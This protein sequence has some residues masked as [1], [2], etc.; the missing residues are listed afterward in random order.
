MKNLFH[1]LKG[2]NRLNTLAVFLLTIA[3]CVTLVILRIQYT[4]KVTFIFLVWNIFLA[5]IPYAIST[6]L[7]LYH[8]KIRYRWLLTIPFLC[9]LCFFPNA[10]Y[11]L[12]DLFHSVSRVFLKKLGLNRLSG[13]ARNVAP[14]SRERAKQD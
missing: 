1:L 7:V 5:L 8:E 13:I 9:W 10:P 6:L 14:E 4:S 2:K 12:T 3:L 11:I